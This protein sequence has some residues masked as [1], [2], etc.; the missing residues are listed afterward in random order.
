MVFEEMKS[1][2]S[3][4]VIE[5]L[6]AVLP[7]ALILLGLVVTVRIDTH[8]SLKQKKAMRWVVAFSLCLV[9]QNF[10]PDY[11]PYVEENKAV[12]TTLSALGYSLRPAILLLYIVI[13]S[14]EKKILPE[15]ILVL[16]NAL[17]YFSAYFWPITFWWSPYMRWMSGPLRN[18]CLFV[19]VILL[20]E[21]VWISV[22]KFRKES[23]REFLLPLFSVIVIIVTV[24][25]DYNV[26]GNH[27]I[28]SFLTDG[29]VIGDLFYY[30]WLHLQFVRE[31]E[32]D[33]QAEQRIRIMMTQ[34]RPHFLFNTLTA[35]RSL[36]RTD[37]EKA[38]QVTML[39][40]N[41]LR[42]NLEAL[43]ANEMIP[44]RKELEYVKIYAD[45][46][47]TRFPNIRVEYDIQDGDFSVPALTV[48]PLVENAIRHGVRIREKGLV[49]VSSRRTAEGHE[50]LIRDNGVGFD[51]QKA[52]AGSGT[53]IGLQNVRERIEKMCRGT[54][55][56]S[57]QPEK[58]TEIVIFIPA[59]PVPIQP[60][61]GHEEV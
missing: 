60:G 33:L 31:H 45:I 16:V 43:E 20:A 48:Q 49:E 38:E 3:Q 8:I 22:R 21:L 29:I 54:L 50:I 11:I 5:L 44:L 26:G 10:L 9:V 14:P 12:H 57:S 2:L 41:Y 1:F 59:D 18:A 35:I 30:L 47:M 36:C 53:H 4:D 34:I 52:S 23:R 39:F 42:Q 7:P 28:I 55:R 61:K 37:P 27:Q 32:K 13:V 56:I 58:G 51:A 40:S 19:S 17:L 25:L 46:E 24:L 6:A 15:M